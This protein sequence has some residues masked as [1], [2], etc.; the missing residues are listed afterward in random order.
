MIEDDSLVE[1]NVIRSPLPF[2]WEYNS[3]SGKILAA[4]K[5]CIVYRSRANRCYELS[6]LTTPIGHAKLF[7]SESCNDCQYFKSIPQST[8]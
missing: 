2:C 4:C 8:N 6:N 1:K 5:G 7:C 3:E